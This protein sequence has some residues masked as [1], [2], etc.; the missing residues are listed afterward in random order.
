[1]GGKLTAVVSA[2]PTPSSDLSPA[3]WQL[4]LALL[5]LAAQNC[6]V[7]AVGIIF[8]VCGCP[9]YAR[10]TVAALLFVLMAEDRVCRGRA[11]APACV[12]R[13]LL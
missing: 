7:K 9:F 12:V 3:A 1:M 2:V 6:V 5:A 10:I 11:D 13:L 8:V 4:M